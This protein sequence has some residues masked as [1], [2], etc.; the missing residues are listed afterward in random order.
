MAWH[1]FKKEEYKAMKG[2]AQRSDG[3]D[4]LRD[5]DETAGTSTISAE[6]RRRQDRDYQVGD[7]VVSVYLHRI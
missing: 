6:E 4:D 3:H 7:F 2:Y 1:G 5:E